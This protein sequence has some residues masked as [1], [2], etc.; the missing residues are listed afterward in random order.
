MRY[1]QWIPNSVRFSLTSVA[2]LT[3][4]L[5]TVLAIGRF[6]SSA[7]DLCPAILFSSWGV[8]QPKSP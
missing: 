2:K 3:H 5:L 8:G 4:I 1:S 7:F 6:L